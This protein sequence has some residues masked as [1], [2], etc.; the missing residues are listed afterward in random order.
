MA[1]Y[2]EPQN[3][4]DYALHMCASMLYF[5]AGSCVLTQ[6][7]KA[8]EIQ[9]QL[10]FFFTDEQIEKAISIITGRKQENDLS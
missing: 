1:T 4:E 8:S 3:P 5:A 9:D 6:D 10:K 7:K 2:F